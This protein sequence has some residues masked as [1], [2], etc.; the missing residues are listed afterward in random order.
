MKI[1]DITLTIQPGMAVWPGDPKVELYRKEKIEDGANANVSFMGISVHTGTHVDAP[2]HFL[3]NG[4]AVDVMPLEVLVGPAVVVELP[5]S[6]KLI[7]AEIINSL[8]FDGSIER[9]LFKTRNSKFWSQ[10]LGEFHPDFVAIS[11]DGAQALI[12]HGIKLTGIDYLS[13]APYKNSKP[14]H[15]TLLKAG[16]VVIEGV[17]LS[18]VQPGKYTLVCMPLKLK[19]TDGSPARTILL[20]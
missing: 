18:K 11:A 3:N 6:V 13:I 9:V 16:M 15:E 17:D 1:Y 5:D 12:D 2:Y 20:G 7:D 10:D 19:D 4:S 14:T 8:S